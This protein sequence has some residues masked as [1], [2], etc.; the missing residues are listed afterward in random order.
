MTKLAGKPPRTEVVKGSATPTGSTKHYT[1]IPNKGDIPVFD[2]CDSILF[3]EV[4]L[5]MLKAV[6]DR[7]KKRYILESRVPRTP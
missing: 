4:C 2:D 6:L 1:I 5:N 3:D 7:K